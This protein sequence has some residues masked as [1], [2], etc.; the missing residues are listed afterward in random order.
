MISSTNDQQYC[1]EPAQLCNVEHQ[2]K[3]AHAGTAT[4]ETEAVLR[5]VAT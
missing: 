5:C 3:M 1:D 2:A 4:N